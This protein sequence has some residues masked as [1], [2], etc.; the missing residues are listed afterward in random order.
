MI[1]AILIIMFLLVLSPML[2]F[3]RSKYYSVMYYGITCHESTN[4]KY[5]GK[6]YKVHLK[7]VNQYAKK[8]LY[9]LGD[10]GLELQD[11]I[12]ASAWTHDC[13]EDCRQTYN[14]VKQ[15]CGKFIAEITYALSN[16]KG[17]IRKE[18][19]DDRYYKGI[20]NVEY[21]DYLKICDRLAN[22]SYSA[23]KKSSMLDKYREEYPEFRMKLYRPEY[24]TMFV[25][26]RSLLNLCTIS[27]SDENNGVVQERI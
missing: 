26:M 14:D 8:Y 21:A 17:K 9:V 5:D 12:L 1:Y 13:I 7:M 27:I 18:R 10:I 23:K 16:E 3:K 24:E 19:A 4:H 20:K 6:P 22:I 25:E 15:N 2:Y 11:L